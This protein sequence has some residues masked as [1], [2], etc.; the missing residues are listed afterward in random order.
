MID[1]TKRPTRRMKRVVQPEHEELVVKIEP[2]PRRTSRRDS[3][4][5]EVVVDDRDP[6]RERG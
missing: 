5:E 3:L 2:A 4:R 1:P 6:R